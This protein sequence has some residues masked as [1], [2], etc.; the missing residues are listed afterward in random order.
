MSARAG[1]SHKFIFGKQLSC[2]ARPVAPRCRSLRAKRRALSK[3]PKPVSPA[4]ST[5]SL[6]ESTMR[7]TTSTSWLQEVSL[8]S[9][10]PREDAIDGPDAQRAL[11][12]ARWAIAPENPSWASTRSVMGFHKKGE[13][14]VRAN[15]RSKY[16]GR[17]RV[18]TSI[19]FGCANRSMLHAKYPRRRDLR[20]LD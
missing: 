15:L 12:P 11:K 20:C 3:F 6:H 9:R 19:G 4:T 10:K 7:S 8:A 1:R 17:W 14:M 13:V 18:R 5:G 2:S 16:I